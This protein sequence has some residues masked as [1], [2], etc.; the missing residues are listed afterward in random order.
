MSACRETGKPRKTSKK[1]PEI[2][3]D[4]DP[5]DLVLEVLSEVRLI[6]AGLWEMRAALQGG[7]TRRDGPDAERGG[8]RILCFG[9]G[10][11]EWKQRRKHETQLRPAGW[12]LKRQG[13]SLDE[14]S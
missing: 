13:S 3:A 1:W 11:R 10:A 9:K 8:A 6:E 4:E 14:E 2:K 7:Y 12:R 5:E